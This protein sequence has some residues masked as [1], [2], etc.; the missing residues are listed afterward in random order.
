MSVLKRN[1]KRIVQGPLDYHRRLW[2]RLYVGLALLVSVS[3]W[4][5]WSRKAG[6]SCSSNAGV[7]QE[8]TTEHQ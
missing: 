3:V 6:A 1:P 4:N 5:A 2:L 7:V 8:S